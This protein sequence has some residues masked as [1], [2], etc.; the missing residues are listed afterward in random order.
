MTKPLLCQKQNKVSQDNAHAA[1]ARY[2]RNGACLVCVCVCVCDHCGR[3]G[4]VECGV[5]LNW[6]RA[7]LTARSSTA[8]LPTTLA[9]PILLGWLSKVFLPIRVEPVL[10]AHCWDVLRTDLPALDLSRLAPPNQMASLVDVLQLENT[11]ARQDQVDAHAHAT[12]PETPT[13]CLPPVCHNL[14]AQPGG[15]RRWGF[16]SHLSFMGKLHQGGEVH[17][18]PN[19]VQQAGGEWSK[20][21]PHYAPGHQGALQDGGQGGN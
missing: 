10:Q 18:S 12:A 17:R 15:G 1:V 16:A 5:L 6:I 4:R 19:R 2:A 21:L 9:L 3:Q 20:R 11:M 14:A 7:A 13:E 8:T